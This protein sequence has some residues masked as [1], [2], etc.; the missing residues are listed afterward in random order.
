MHITYKHLQDP[1]DIE[2]SKDF[3][4]SFV[5]DC[6][7][8]YHK[9]LTAYHSINIRIHHNQRLFCICYFI[10]LFYYLCFS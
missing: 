6:W 10:S 4:P 1:E 2:E 3:D 8:D 5:I 7:L 9:T